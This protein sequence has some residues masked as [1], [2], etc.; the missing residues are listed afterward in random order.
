MWITFVNAL[1][2]VLGDFTLP[3]TSLSYLSLPLYISP[4][5]FLSLS[6]FS[7][8]FSLAYLMDV[9]VLVFLSPARCAPEFHVGLSSE[10]LILNSIFIFSSHFEIAIDVIRILKRQQITIFSRLMTWIYFMVKRN[11]KKKLY[12]VRNFFLHLA[13]NNSEFFL[14]RNRW[15]FKW[16]TKIMKI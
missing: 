9:F 15:K 12:L 13:K 3:F 7:L 14:S 8:S 16:I 4:S 5:T 1:F 10:T 2:F 6:L 11:G